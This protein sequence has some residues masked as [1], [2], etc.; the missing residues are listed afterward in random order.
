MTFGSA[1]RW[2]GAAGVGKGFLRC[3]YSIGSL[4]DLSSLPVALPMQDL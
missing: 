1:V 2:P 3:D 4:G